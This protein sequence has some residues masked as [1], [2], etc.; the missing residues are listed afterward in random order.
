ME[1]SISVYI[2]SIGFLVLS[3]SYLFHFSPLLL[4]ACGLRELR[5]YDQPANGKWQPIVFK[6]MT[7]EYHLE[8]GDETDNT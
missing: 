1:G 4:R 6:I 8:F 5:Q 2:Q 7:L 3:D